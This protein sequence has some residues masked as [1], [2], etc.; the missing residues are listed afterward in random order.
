MNC[1]RCETPYPEVARF[2]AACGADVRATDAAGQA[3]RRVFAAHPGE[4][5]VS[6]NVVTSMMPLASATAPQTYK[7]AL[8]IGLAIPVI[9]SLFG[10]LPFALATAAVVVPIVYILYLYDVNEWEDQPVPVVLGTVAVAGVLSLL[11]TL[12][13]RDGILGS[14]A[15]AA[16]AMAVASSA[17]SV[18]TWAST[19]RRCSSS[20]CS[21]RSC[22]RCSSRSARS[23]W[24]PRRSSTT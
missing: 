13:W 23:G 11:F 7:F 16:A 18:R 6:F 19:R 1:P 3:R 15:L 22:P 17:M 2:C 14:V 9:A 5:L 20:G 8:A 21:Y 10:L 12:L 24:R 4:P